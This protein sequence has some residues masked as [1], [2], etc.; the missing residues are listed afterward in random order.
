MISGYQLVQLLPNIQGKKV[1]IFTR[2]LLLLFYLTMCS[3]GIFLQGCSEART[4]KS[5]NAFDS[6]DCYLLTV[7]SNCKDIL[8]VCARHSDNYLRKFSLFEK[9][10]C[11]PLNK[12]TKESTQKTLREVNTDFVEKFQSIAKLT[13]EL[14]VRFLH[15]HGPSPSF[16]F[17]QKD[18]DLLI[19]LG[20]VLS[21][22]S[23]ELRGRSG[24]TYHLSDVDS[25]LATSL[26]G[27]R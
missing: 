13:E 2:Q 5:L 8:N 25:E 23:V 27:L 24:R 4:F 17:P 16:T 26:L 9:K 7:R 3:I 20:M 18:D 11:D 12:H 10:C 6:K 22:A 21:R 19:T 15:P 14:K 1:V